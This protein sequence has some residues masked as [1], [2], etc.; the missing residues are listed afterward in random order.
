M[1]N[2]RFYLF[3]RATW[4]SASPTSY[5]KSFAGSLLRKPH[6][7]G[8]ASKNLQIVHTVI[9]AC[10]C[11]QDIRVGN[12]GFALTNVL[13]PGWKATARLNLAY[14]WPVG[15]ACC[16]A[17]GLPQREVGLPDSDLWDR[18]L[19]LGKSSAVRALINTGAS[20]AAVLACSLLLLPRVEASRQERGADSGF[21]AGG[22]VILIPN[23]LNSSF[24]SSGER[25]WLG[26]KQ[27]WIFLQ[28]LIFLH[29]SQKRPCTR[30]PSCNNSGQY[31]FCMNPP[32]NNI[33]ARTPK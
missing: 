5:G 7:V 32:R 13:P 18:K 1:D 25:L 27:R 8:S 28:K 29:N 30:I 24:S 22:L 17:S 6:M 23:T 3:S 4:P 11:F 31:Y 12:Y 2:V 14:C 16:P 26:F 19:F 21:S 10:P 20:G 33:S 15:C 9:P